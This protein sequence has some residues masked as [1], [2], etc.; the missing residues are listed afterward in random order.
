MRI[1]FRFALVVFLLLSFGAVTALPQESLISEIEFAPFIVM[2]EELLHRFAA[3]EGT[4][5]LVDIRSKDQFAAGRIRGAVHFEWPHEG[6]A[7][8]DS[9]GR[10]LHLGEP[11]DGMP[12][13]IDVLLI[14]EAGEKSFELLR[15]LLRRG[16]SRVWVVEGGMQNWPYGEYL[17]TGVR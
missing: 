14:D 7:A 8:P 10:S 16:Y 12:P 4:Y 17:E 5:L 1:I 15:F 3:G 11:L 9:S 13:D 6:T 2:P